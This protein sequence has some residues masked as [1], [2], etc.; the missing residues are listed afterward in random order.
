MSSDLDNTIPVVG[1]P[2]DQDRPCDW[3]GLT[4]TAH[5][6]IVPAKYTD[7]VLKTRAIKAYVC[8][9]HGRQL[10]IVPGYGVSA[11]DRVE[12]RAMVQ[13]YLRSLRRQAM[14]ANQQTLFP[15][16]RKPDSAILEG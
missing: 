12:N 13:A 5:V 6:T 14:W 8:P 3:C 4:P 11:A 1:K 16:E 9:G 7:G 15:V 10:Q 2:Y